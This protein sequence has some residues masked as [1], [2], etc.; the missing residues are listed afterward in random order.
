MMRYLVFDT[1]DA[2]LAESEA[3]AVA[4]GCGPSTRYWWRVIQTATGWAVEVPIGDEGTRVADVDL[5]L[6]E[7]A[8]IG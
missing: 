6:A 5:V 8:G 2:A 1:L 4:R 3:E 7:A